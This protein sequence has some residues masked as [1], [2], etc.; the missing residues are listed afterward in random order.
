MKS[1]S[2]GLVLTAPRTSTRRPA[3]YLGKL[4]RSVPSSSLSHPPP[5]RTTNC[6]KPTRLV[7]QQES[8]G[9]T[10]KQHCSAHVFFVGRIAQTVTARIGVR[11]GAHAN[12]QQRINLNTHHDKG[13]WFSQATG[14]CCASAPNPEGQMSKVQPRFKLRLWGRGG[15]ATPELHFLQG[16]GERS[17]YGHCPKDRGLGWPLPK[18]YTL[19]TL[20]GRLLSLHQRT[21]VAE[22]LRKGFGSFSLP[23]RS[24]SLQVFALWGGLVADD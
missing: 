13:N 6:K 5:P 14:A 16:D 19:S 7:A 9:G 17:G 12:R 20:N 23:S 18:P 1:G 11:A 8:P 15:G 3:A 10:V 21:W 22:R 24:W 2:E 4:G